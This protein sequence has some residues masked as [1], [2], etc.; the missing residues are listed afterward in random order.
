MLPE[1]VVILKVLLQKV[2]FKVQGNGEL[3]VNHLE[4]ALLRTTLS[5]FVD[6]VVVWMSALAVLEQEVD[7][8]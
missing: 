6:F 8:K 3:N 1:I 4:S 2:A 7:L 5:H